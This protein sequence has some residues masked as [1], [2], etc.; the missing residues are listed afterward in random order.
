M[1]YISSA[2][3][4]PKKLRNDDK[5]TP[6][7]GYLW[8]G[9]SVQF[10]EPV[11]PARTSSHGLGVDTCVLGWRSRDL[12]RRPFLRPSLWGSPRL[13]L[14]DFLRLPLWGSPC[15]LL[16]DFHR[17]LLGSFLPSHRL[18]L[19]ACAAR[20]HLRAQWRSHQ[21]FVIIRPLKHCG[22]SRPSGLVITKRDAT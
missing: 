19:H 9:L 5:V 18:F 22:P 2:C 16:E 15:S 13:L 7:Q 8:F 21:N 3:Q 10:L 6:R 1:H 4:S 17:P 14:G 11:V 20:R 12:C